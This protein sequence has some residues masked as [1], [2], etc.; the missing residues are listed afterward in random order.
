MGRRSQTE[1]STVDAWKRARAQSAHRKADVAEA[2]TKFEAAAGA[3]PAMDLGAE[4]AARPGEAKPQQ[5]A[6]P[7]TDAKPLEE[8]D[9]TSRLLKAKQRAAKP[10]DKESPGG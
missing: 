5:E 3:P 1:T 4:L 2:A 9:Y 10:E 6:K 7:A 8:G